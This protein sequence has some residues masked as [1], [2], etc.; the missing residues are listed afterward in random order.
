M[1][2]FIKERFKEPS[3][4]IAMISLGSAFGIY[5][6]DQSQALTSLVLALSGAQGFLT[7]A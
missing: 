1:F 5:T 6:Y 7:K 2:E 3:T 4:W